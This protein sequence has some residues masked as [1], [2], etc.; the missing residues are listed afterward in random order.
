MI[1]IVFPKNNEEKFIEIASKLGYEK[2]CFVYEFKGKPQFKEIKAEFEK[3]RKETRLKLAL[4]ALCNNDIDADLIFAKAQEKLP[5]NFDIIIQSPN[6][7]KWPHATYRQLKEKLI[8]IPFSDLLT[9]NN[10]ETVLAK[11]DRFIFLC[12]KYR[13]TFAL[14]SYAKEPYDMRSVHDLKSFFLTLGMH[15]AD[16]K[17]GFNSVEKLLEEKD[18]L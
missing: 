16:V 17:S 6:I 14:G 13:L 11:L 1:D 18:I 15:P 12:R 10:R 9:A 4:C 2:L 8:G 3:L 5:M 7:V